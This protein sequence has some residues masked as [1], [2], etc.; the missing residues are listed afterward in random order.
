M[1]SFSWYKRGWHCESV[2]TPAGEDATMLGTAVPGMEGVLVS[3]GP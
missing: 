1:A 3:I 2:I